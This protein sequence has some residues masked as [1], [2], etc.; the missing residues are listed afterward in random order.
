MRT[1]TYKHTRAHIDA[2]A[3]K[4]LETCNEPTGRLARAPIEQQ[5]KQWPLIGR[6]GNGKRTSDAR[7]QKL[8]RFARARAF[9]PKSA[10]L[11]SR[12]QLETRALPALPGTTFYVCVCVCVGAG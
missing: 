11:E 8:Q 4:P 3:L 10:R 6:P 12:R 9:S 1:R 2:V 7:A 5:T